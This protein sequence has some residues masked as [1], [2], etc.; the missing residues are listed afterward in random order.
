MA[1]ASCDHIL[2][3]GVGP[4]E[5]HVRLLQRL[6]HTGGGAHHVQRGVRGR[7]RLDAALLLVLLHA[8]LHA[9]A[10]GCDAVEVVVDAPP[11]LLLGHGP[12]VLVQ[13]LQ[14]HAAPGV[15][16]LPQVHPGALE[17]VC[18][19]DQSAARGGRA[20]DEAL[21]ARELEGRGDA[22]GCEGL[23]V[24]EVEVVGLPGRPRAV[25]RGASLVHVEGPALAAGLRAVAC[26]VH[27]GR[28]LLLD[29]WLAPGAVRLPGGAPG[30]AQA[31]RGQL[32]LGV[33]VGAHGAEELRRL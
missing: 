4:A 7:G 9:L 5:H 25:R 23:L 18:A 26:G 28:P 12:P 13:V 20:A 6:L 27:W 17:V 2:A 24:E 11:C 1:R 14:G 21:G 8:L 16:P 10:P 3:H 19:P 29:A 33:P 22:P 31:L 32:T 15:V 30:E